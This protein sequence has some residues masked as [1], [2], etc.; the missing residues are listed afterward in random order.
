MILIFDLDDTLYDE[1]EYVK[2]GFKA[3]SIYLEEKYSLNQG[4]T[5]SF[6]LKSLKDN[7]R[8]KIFDHLLSHYGFLSKKNLSKC[9]SCYRTHNPSIKIK[10]Q[11]LSL[12][13]SLKKHNKLYIVT[14]G[15]K[16]VQKKKIN[17]LN[18]EHLFKKIFITH[19]FGIKNAKPSLHCF[20]IIKK[21]ENCKWD[22]IYYIGDNPYKDFANLNIV[23]ANTIRILNCAYKEI[24]PKKGYEAHKTFKSINDLLLELNYER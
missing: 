23:G 11:T 22:D 2:S 9:I 12:L 1:I 5:L 17:A 20:Q 8:G 10:E 16:I 3:V 15:N 13:I 21:N 4:E 6:M 18:I 7:G 24:N 14:D 19:R